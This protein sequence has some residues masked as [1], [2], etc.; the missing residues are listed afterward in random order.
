MEHADRLQELQKI[1]EKDI[2]LDDWFQERDNLVKKST[3]DHFSNDVILTKKDQD[4]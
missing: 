2:N 4:A 1:A 3:A